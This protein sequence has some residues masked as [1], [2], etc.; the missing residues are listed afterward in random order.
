LER[1]DGVIAIPNRAVRR[2]RQGTYA[3]VVKD[4]TRVR[5]DIRV[6]YRGRDFTEV[7]EGLDEGERVI[8]G[9]AAE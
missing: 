8:V 3:F 1:R 9:T 7:V 4:G 2:D 6:G 5:R